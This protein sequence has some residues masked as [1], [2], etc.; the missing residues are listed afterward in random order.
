MNEHMNNGFLWLAG[1]KHLPRVMIFV[2]KQLTTK[3]IHSLHQYMD[4]RTDRL[5]R[6]LVVLFSGLPRTA[7]QVAHCPTPGASIDN[8]VNGSSN[9]RHFILKSMMG[10][11][12]PLHSF[13]NYLRPRDMTMDKVSSDRNDKSSGNK[14]DGGSTWCFVSLRGKLLMQPVAGSVRE[15]WGWRSGKAF[16]KKLS[17]TGRMNRKYPGNTDGWESSKGP[18]FR[19]LVN[20]WWV[21]M[22]IDHCSQHFSFLHNT[23]I[24]I[25]PNLKMHEVSQSKPE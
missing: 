3:M 5:W 22:G 19:A 14:Y 1:V 10:G 8:S 20:P 12:H 23:F 25:I 16:W 13:I 15:G 24:A 7:A 4:N 18:E 17:E 2:L 9:K 21:I 6:Q 11:K